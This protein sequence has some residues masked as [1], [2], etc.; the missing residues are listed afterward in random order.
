MEKDISLFW[1]YV[2]N[3]S[4]RIR[5]KFQY[6]AYEMVRLLILHLVHEQSVPSG[7]NNDDDIASIPWDQYDTNTMLSLRMHKSGTYDLHFE[8]YDDDQE[9]Y[10]SATYV[11]THKETVDLP[12]GIKWLLSETLQSGKPQTLDPNKIGNFQ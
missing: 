8:Y 3:N 12:E 9:D 5:Q 7:L 11:L 10:V 4:P 2:K 1:D 6:Q